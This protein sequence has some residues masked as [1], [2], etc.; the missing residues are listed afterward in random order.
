MKSIDAIR[1][2]F[3]RDDKISPGGG[4]KM[5]NAEIMFFARSNPTGSLRELAELAAKELG[6]ELTS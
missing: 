2:F 5:E 3:E 6:V 1:I 4:R